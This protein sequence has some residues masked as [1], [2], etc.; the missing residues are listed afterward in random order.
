[1]S[2]L[3]GQHSGRA[4]MLSGVAAAIA[5]MTLNWAS[6]PGNLL[7]SGFSLTRASDG[8]YFDSAG[9]LQTAATDVARGTYRYPTTAPRS[10]Q[11]GQ[12]PGTAGSYFSTPDSAANSITGDIDIRVKVAMND[13]SPGGYDNLVS[14]FVG[15]N[16]DYSLQ[17]DSGTGG[18]LFFVGNNGAWYMNSAV[19]GFVDGTTHWVRATRSAS[20]GTVAFYTSD[21]GVSWEVLANNSGITP[22]GNLQDIV[23]SLGIGGN[24]SGPTPLAGKVY[25][26][27]VYNGINGTLAVNFNSDDYASGATWTASTTG[28]TWTVNGAASIAWPWVFDGTMIEAA[29]T[30]LVT[31]VRDM[32]T[33]NWTRGATITVALTGTGADGTANSCSRLT[34]GAV[35]ATNRASQT[36]VA[37]ASTRVYGPLIKRVTGSGPIL[38]T[39]DGFV[40]TTDVSSQINS[41]TFTQ[42][43]ITGSTL[44]AAYGVQVSTNGDVILVD[45]NQFEAGSASTST[46]LTGATRAADIVTAT[47]SGLQVGAQG[48]AAGAFRLIAEAVTGQGT[49]LSTDTGGGVAGAQSYW[50]GGAMYMYDTTG[51]AFGVAATPT[52]GAVNKV[53]VSWG[54]G[55]NGWQ[56]S[57]NGVVASGNIAFDGNMNFAGTMRIGASTTGTLPIS[58]VLQSLRLG[59]QT[60]NNS[61]LANPFA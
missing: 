34:G 28:E 40:T 61:R 2:G 16:Y 49:F 19:T 23:A 32:T 10:G 39:Q 51:G 58:M 59:V 60:V 31:D 14:K 20:T 4:G 33:V 9:L 56:N 42:V 54:A 17:F 11:W 48:F 18:R 15:G 47:T 5:G 36:L 44:N 55:T 35:A 7:P 27:Q 24:S 29:A 12:L 38:I 25:Q 46:I 41:A 3:N 21:D 45:G 57:L 53:A 43:Q 1:M 37:A 26:A 30:N 13:W 52:V 6:S 50:F 8:T 22:A